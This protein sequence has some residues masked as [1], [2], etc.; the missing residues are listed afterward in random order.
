VAA[1]K[2]ARNVKPKQKQKKKRAN[3]QRFKK[4]KKNNQ[5]ESK[6]QQ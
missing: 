1:E 2:K 6:P 4:L 5:K 3:L